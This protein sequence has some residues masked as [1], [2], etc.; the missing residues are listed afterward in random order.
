MS[1]HQ[2]PTYRDGN[3]TADRALTILQMFSANRTRVSATDVADHLGVSRSTAYRYL[4]TLVGSSFLTEDVAGGFRLGSKVMELAGIA[5]RSHGLSEMVLPAMRKLADRLH[6]TV[7]LTK[8]IGT[9]IVCLEREEWTGR[10]IRLSYERGSQL[11]YNAGASALILLAWLPEPEVRH[12]LSSRSLPAYSA[13][14]LTE[15]DA[16]VQRLAQIRLDGYA[17]G[18]GEVDADAMGIAAPVFAPDGA[19]DA[20]ISVVMLQARADDTHLTEIVKTVVATA[21][22]LSEE[23]SLYSA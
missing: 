21:R 18:R 22:A 11:S 9:A 19:V 14:T 4:Q 3:S 12:L 23:L 8:R 20:A 7:L 17:V 6:E 13:T 1:A 15:P 5:R 16:I 2:R 10:N